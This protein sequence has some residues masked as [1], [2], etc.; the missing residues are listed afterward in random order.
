MLIYFTKAQIVALYKYIIGYKVYVIY[1]PYSINC[2][3]R[4]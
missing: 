3:F 2:L 1:K 4:L